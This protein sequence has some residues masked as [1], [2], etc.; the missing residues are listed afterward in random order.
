MPR[1]FSQRFPRRIRMAKR[2]GRTVALHVMNH[3]NPLAR[4]DHVFTDIDLLGWNERKGRGGC[5][6]A[7]FFYES[8][9]TIR[10]QMKSR[11]CDGYI[12]WIVTH[13]RALYRSHGQATQT[14]YEWSGNDL[15][16]LGG[17]WG[18]SPRTLTTVGAEEDV[19]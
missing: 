15:S 3:L 14:S 8:N 17:Y 4:N 12:E 6:S 9:V 13:V 16:D 1:F 18:N 7:T 2:V 10:V 11:N 19:A 5:T